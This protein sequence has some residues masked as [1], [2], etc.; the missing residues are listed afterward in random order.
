VRER[1]VALKRG[2]ESMVLEKAAR[3]EQGRD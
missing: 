1:V 3:M 2:L